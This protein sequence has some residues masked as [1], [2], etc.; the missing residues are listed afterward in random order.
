[1]RVSLPP[2]GRVLSFYRARAAV[3]NNRNE[4]APIVS[5]RLFPLLLEELDPLLYAGISL[6]GRFIN[7][8]DAED[9]RVK[10]VG[11]IN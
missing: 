2:F 3:F 10:V 9:A 4:V 1:M 8:R 6:H 5:G 11:P 7:D